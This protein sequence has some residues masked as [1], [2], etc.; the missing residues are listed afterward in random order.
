[1]PVFQMSV[2]QMSAQAVGRGVDWRLESA[3]PIDVG[4]V[5]LLG[6]GLLLALTG[7]QFGRQLA[8]AGSR[9]MGAGGNLDGVGSVQAEVH[10]G[11]W[12]SLWALR[13]LVV[14]VLCWMLGGWRIARFETDLPD[15]VVLIDDSESMQ[16][17]AGA[18]R[19]SVAEKTRWQAVV[20]LVT[21]GE[22][23]WLERLAEEY[24]LRLLSVGAE[25]ENLPGDVAELVA[26]LRT[27]EPT[28]EES[29]LG[30]Q[31]AA[32][33]EAQRGRSTAAVVLLSDGVV[34]AGESLRQAAGGAQALRLPLIIA[35]IGS[36][37][38]PPQVSLSELVAE[39]T[40][41]VGD[42]VNVMARIQWTAAGDQATRVMLI[43]QSSGRELASQEIR[44]ESAS[45]LA[46]GG[47]RSEV[48]NLSFLAEQA[49]LRDLRVRVEPLAGEV[50]LEDNEGV[51][52]V[53]VRDDSFRVLLIQGA[54][55]YEFRFLKHLLERATNRD[56][57]RPL[58]E[59]ISVLQQGDPR[60]ADQDRAA[61][62]LPPVDS[63]TL[64][65]LDLIILSDCN[66]ASLGTV[67]Q[68]K[69]AELVVEQGVSLV[70]VAGPDHLPAALAG[71]PLG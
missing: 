51:V 40:A 46:R 71:T 4:W 65:S 6:I 67:L 38:P 53:D 54:A 55:S 31:L 21:T 12:L 47:G 35:H 39:S 10:W 68:T 58:V 33:V 41:M 43:D 69:L 25:R 42:S 44:S 34:T 1:M 24:R 22:G 64:E 59:L 50:A 5:W 56:G 15:L 36:T 45:L 61:A 7:L 63:E 37:E 17:P 27:T 8:G 57:T 18:E 9:L 29:R 32:V 23:E 20:D 60:Y 66:P 2:F 70:V 52:T 26:A 3:W 11:R 30:D 13:A 19:Q 28:G 48:I 16:L 14:V 62:R 49:G